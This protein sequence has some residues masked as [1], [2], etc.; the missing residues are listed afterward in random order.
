MVKLVKSSVWGCLLVASVALA[1]QPAGAAAEAFSIE[2]V[3]T[4]IL[5]AGGFYSL[6][7]VGCADGGSASVVSLDNRA[8]WCTQ[9][10]SELVCF[11][12]RR[13]A[14][15]LACAG[16]AVADAAQGADSP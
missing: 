16:E 3:K 1:G 12:N 5:P 13:E 8:R 11:N 2:K 6:F 10:G 4:G 15:R 9:E 14:A 7:A